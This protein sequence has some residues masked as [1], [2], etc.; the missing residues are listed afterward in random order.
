MRSAV[1]LVKF[2]TRIASLTLT[3]SHRI[4]AVPTRQAPIPD[5][6]GAS[7]KVPRTIGKGPSSMG[8]LASSGG[9]QPPAGATSG[10]P[11][12]AHQ[13]DEDPGSGL[14]EPDESLRR[15][16]PSRISTRVDLQ[17]GGLE[18]PG[19]HLKD[20]A[21]AR[22]GKKAV[23]QCTGSRRLGCGVVERESPFCTR[24]SLAASPSCKQRDN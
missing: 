5:G 13:V 16:G 1:P 19:L 17:G 14:I 7:A 23:P 4:N 20:L 3:S 11:S 21:K 10:F 6:K 18:H 8:A 12:W 15:P 24:A 22:P 9:G 2:Q